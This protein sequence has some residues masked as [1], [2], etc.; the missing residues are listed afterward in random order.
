MLVTKYMGKQF[1]YQSEKHLLI[2]VSLITRPSCTQ[3]LQLE[4]FQFCQRQSTFQREGWICI[5]V[6][7]MDHISGNCRER[8]LL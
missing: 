2:K 3:G 7:Q 6:A 5:C 4:S 1:A 8:A